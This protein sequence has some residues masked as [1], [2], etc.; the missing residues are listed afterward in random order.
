MNF[1]TFDTNFER[2]PIV[3]PEMQNRLRELAMPLARCIAEWNMHAGVWVDVDGIKL[4][5]VDC[6]SAFTDS[7]E[8]EI[9]RESTPGQSN[10]V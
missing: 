5:S 3:T 9:L 8:D 1:S 4:I 6:V 10:P 7:E 2:I